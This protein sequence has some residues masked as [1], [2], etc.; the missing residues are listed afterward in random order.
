M[1]VDD[2]C[3]ICAAFHRG[4]VRHRTTGS[5]RNKFVREPRS[6]A[7]NTGKATNDFAESE[8]WMRPNPLLEPFGH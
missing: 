3:A 2:K 1:D 6:L 8:R 5:C 4:D 7:Q